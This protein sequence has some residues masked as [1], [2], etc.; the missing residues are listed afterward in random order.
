MTVL[1]KIAWW[2]YLAYLG[3]YER[4]G[5]RHYSADFEVCGDLLCRLVRP[6]DRFYL[7]HWDACSRFLS[8][9]RR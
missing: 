2:L 4:H 7:N 9:V 5:D 8:G 3:V 6:I 1:R